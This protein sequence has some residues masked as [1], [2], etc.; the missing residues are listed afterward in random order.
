[1]GAGVGGKGVGVTV[2]VAVA[3]RAATMSRPCRAAS[4]GPSLA[5]YLFNAVLRMHK[6]SA[7]VYDVELGELSGQAVLMNGALAYAS[8]VGE[9]L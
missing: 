6:I 8:L 7:Y 1:M 9:R 3:K 2:G 5:A 4:G